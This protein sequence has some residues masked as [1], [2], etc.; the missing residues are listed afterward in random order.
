MSLAVLCREHAAKAVTRFVKHNALQ[1]MQS[2]CVVRRTP[3][4]CLAEKQLP[5]PVEHVLRYD[6]FVF[7]IVDN[8]AMT[9]FADVDWVGEQVA[10]MAAAEASN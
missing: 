7:A 8:I 1:K 10:K 4:R 6:G 5:H 3:P 2:L 9:D